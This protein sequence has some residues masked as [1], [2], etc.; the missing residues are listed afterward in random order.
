M[1]CVQ[2]GPQRNLQRTTQQQQQQ[3]TSR[4]MVRSVL[5]CCAM[6]ATVTP[7]LSLH[8]HAALLSC[9]AH[10]RCMLRLGP[11]SCVVLSSAEPRFRDSYREHT[12]HH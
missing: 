8:Q 7:T 10:E 3:Q 1:D 4:S 5:C 6:R 9:S 11:S 2:G 12:T